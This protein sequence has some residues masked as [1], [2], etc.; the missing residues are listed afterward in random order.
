ME[1]VAKI[2]ETK[3]LKH[4]GKAVASIVLASLSLAAVCFLYFNA[5]VWLTDAGPFAHS[6]LREITFMF[7]TPVALITMAGQILGILS[8]YGQKN[9]KATL[10]ICL[11]T[12]ALVL[13]ILLMAYVLKITIDDPFYS[14]R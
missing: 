12:A 13:F 1:K 2:I 6:I 3:K 14:W 4:G 11:S 9:T 7:A 10:G 8:L 5:I